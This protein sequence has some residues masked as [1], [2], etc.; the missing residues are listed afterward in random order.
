MH[1]GGVY[2]NQSRP[3]QVASDPSCTLP[4][5]YVAEI[6]SELEVDALSPELQPFPRL[7]TGLSERAPTGEVWLNGGDVSADSD[8]TVVLDVAGEAVKDGASFP[9]RASLTISAK[10]RRKPVPPHRPGAEPICKQRI[11]TPIQVDVTP[12]RGGRLIL[13]VDPARMFTNVDFKNLVP[14][15]DGVFEIEDDDT[16][17]PNRSLYDGLR[18]SRSYTIHWEDE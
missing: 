10:N 4:G 7:G 3:T 5:I 17:G 1:V 16:P 6:A 9:F 12:R 15:S 13:E 14:G 8:P 2:L 18:S 11:V